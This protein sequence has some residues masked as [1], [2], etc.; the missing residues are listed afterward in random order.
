MLD[1]GNGCGTQASPTLQNMLSN[2]FDA[3]VGGLAGE[4]WSSTE[5]SGDANQYTW[6]QTFNTGD[7]P[8]FT[9]NKDYSLRVRCS[10]TLTP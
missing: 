6:S 5:W 10:R 4:Y 7:I 1:S 3:E 8:Q 9:V 2:L